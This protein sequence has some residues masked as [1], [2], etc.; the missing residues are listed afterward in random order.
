MSIAEQRAVAW[1]T[2][3]MGNSESRISASEVRKCIDSIEDE[4]LSGGYESGV[5]PESVIMTM[6]T[7]LLAVEN[8]GGNVVVPKATGIAY[9]R[10]VV[11]S[12]FPKSKSRYSVSTVASSRGYKRYKKPV[13]GMYTESAV[14]VPRSQSHGITASEARKMRMQQRAEGRSSNV[15][16]RSSG[17]SAPHYNDNS[18]EVDPDLAYEP[19]GASAALDSTIDALAGLNIRRLPKETADVPHGSM[20]NDD[21]VFRGPPAQRGVGSIRDRARALEGKR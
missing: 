6:R 19:A 15:R 4:L 3:N 10:D 18:S 14:E 11:V 17:A 8:D 16:R 7:M 5:T 1:E 9:D 21:P 13:S 2:A 12:C 20:R